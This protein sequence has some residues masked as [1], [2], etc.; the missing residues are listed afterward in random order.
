VAAALRKRWSGW[1]DGV[2]VGGIADL[3]ISRSHDW[4]LQIADWCVGELT[5]DC[6]L[7]DCR[8]PR[9][10]QSMSQSGQSAIRNSQS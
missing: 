6:R 2:G 9:N 7:V 5:D 10:R 1:S 8:N 4:E 3:T